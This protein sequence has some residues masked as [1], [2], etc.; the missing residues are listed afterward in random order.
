MVCSDAHD[1]AHGAHGPCEATSRHDDDHHF[2]DSDTFQEPQVY[3][4]PEEEEIMSASERTPMLQKRHSTN[5][6][7]RP[8]SMQRNYSSQRQLLYGTMGSHGKDCCLNDP[9]KIRQLLQNG[10][11]SPSLS[12][13]SAQIGN[14]NGHGHHEDAFHAAHHMSHHSEEHATPHSTKEQHSSH[15]SAH[16]IIGVA[17]LEFGVVLHSFV[18]GM[19]LAVVARFPTLFVVIALHRKSSTFSKMKLSNKTDVC[20]SCRDVR[21]LRSGSETCRTQPSQETSLG[22]CCCSL[23]FLSH[24]TSRTRCWFACT[25]IV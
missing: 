23:P 18:V 10:H 1:H 13:R 2:L 16:Q 11:A 20:L 12:A 14:D 4:I 15:R 19:T 5:S 8:R 9:R 6:M 3:T 22:T 21:G 7:R 24:Y 17:I 25:E